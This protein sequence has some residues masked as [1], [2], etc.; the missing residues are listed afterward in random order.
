M[1]QTVKLYTE[2]IITML[3]SGEMINAEWVISFVQYIRG[4]RYSLQC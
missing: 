4:T 3:M 1:L 2:L